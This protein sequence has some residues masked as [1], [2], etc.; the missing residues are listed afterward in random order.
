MVFDQVLVGKKIGDLSGYVDELK[1]LLAVSDEEILRDPGK[2]HIAERL[3]Q[4]IVDTMIDI[5]QH[6]IREKKLPP[7]DDYQSTFRTMGEHGLLPKEFTEKLAP[8]VGLRNMVVHRYEHLDKQTFIQLLRK[9]LDDFV[10]YR[11]AILGTL[12]EE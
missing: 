2:Q 4:L 1:A 6:Y 3:F 11:D 10:Y 8:V 7:S 5:N 9:N 12:P